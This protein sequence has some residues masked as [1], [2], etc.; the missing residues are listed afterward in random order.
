MKNP[1]VGKKNDF[2]LL[3]CKILCNTYSLERGV[4]FKEFGICARFCTR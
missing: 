2:F 4:G 3:C 1:I